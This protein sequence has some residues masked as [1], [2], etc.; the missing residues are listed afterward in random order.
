MDHPGGKTIATALERVAHVPELGHNICVRVMDALS[1]IDDSHSHSRVLPIISKTLPTCRFLRENTKPANQG[2]AEM[3]DLC[4]SAV[5]EYKVSRESKVSFDPQDGELIG[6]SGG[7][8][9]FGDVTLV[10]GSSILAF[11]LPIKDSCGE[12]LLTILFRFQ[13]R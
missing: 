2:R 13:S 11:P 9:L 10:Q 7:R 12:N 4:P 3:A 5:G 6:P 8:G 1:V